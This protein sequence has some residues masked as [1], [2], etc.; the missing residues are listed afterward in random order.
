[1]WWG[2][3]KDYENHFTLLFDLIKKYER[4]LKFSKNRSSV[5]SG[6]LRR[7]IKYFWL[8]FFHLPDSNAKTLFSLFAQPHANTHTV[9]QNPSSHV[10][11]KPLKR[12]RERMFEVCGDCLFGVWMLLWILA[13]VFLWELVLCVCGAVSSLPI[14]PPYRLFHDLLVW[15][16]LLLKRT[17][18]EGGRI[19][20]T[21][22]GEL[23]MSWW[24][25]KSTDII[26]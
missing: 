17:T 9:T 3:L 1:M 24:R 20:K 19:P 15:S 16:P 18:D 21:K 11:W 14:C 22:S 10:S 7:R 25:L 12:N 4:I 6:S 13:L 5:D 23:E 26:K 8:S 2:G